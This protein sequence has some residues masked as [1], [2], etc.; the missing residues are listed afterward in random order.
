MTS[1]S[2]RAASAEPSTS[3]ARGMAISVRACSAHLADQLLDRVNRTIVAPGPGTGRP[4]CRDFP[5]I[6]VP[7]E[8]YAKDRSRA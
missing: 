3:G 4:S 2:P 1:V 8:S 7:P 5:G 6:G